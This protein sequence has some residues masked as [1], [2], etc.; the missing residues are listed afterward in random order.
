MKRY[1]PV[2]KWMRYKGYRIVRKCIES[3]NSNGFIIPG[4][5]EYS[6][7]ILNPVDRDTIKYAFS[8]REVKQWI[9]ERL[10]LT[11]GAPV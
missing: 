7:E 2:K 9:N 3:I 1:D 4:E 5:Y 8:M 11:K 10:K 6:Y